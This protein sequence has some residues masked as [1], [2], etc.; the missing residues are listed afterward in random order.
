MSMTRPIKLSKI[1]RA[2]KT[3]ATTG[4]CLS[5]CSATTGNAAMCL[6]HDSVAQIGVFSGEQFLRELITALVHIAPRPGEVIVDPRFCRAAE[7]IR[8]GQSLIRRFALVHFV[9]RVR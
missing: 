1:P 4:R 3:S 6:A 2:R 5:T 7:I 8:D 9:L